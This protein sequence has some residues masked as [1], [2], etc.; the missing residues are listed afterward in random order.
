MFAA[1]RCFAGAEARGGHHILLTLFFFL[2][3]TGHPSSASGFILTFN[4]ILVYIYI[5][6]SVDFFF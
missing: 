4:S 1:K 5:Y 3:I 2:L 6:N